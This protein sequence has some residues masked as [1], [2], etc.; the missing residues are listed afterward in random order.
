MKTAGVIKI[1][2]L[3][4]SFLLIAI[5]PSG[6]VVAGE[7]EVETPPPVIFVL[8]SSDDVVRVS[9]ELNIMFARRFFC[10]D[11]SGY[12]RVAN[13]S[14]PIK[15]VVLSGSKSTYDSTFTIQKSVNGSYKFAFGSAD[16][17]TNIGLDGIYPG[18]SRL[19]LSNSSSFGVSF[20]PG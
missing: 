19:V 16:K 17:P 10:R 1:F 3:M 8:S 4:L 18:I 5:T 7:K 12:W 13:S 6:A 14:L 15:E 20:I 9:T 2:G 11:E